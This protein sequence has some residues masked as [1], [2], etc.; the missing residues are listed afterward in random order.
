MTR[1]EIAKRFLEVK[2]SSDLAKLFN[3]TPRQLAYV[4]YH[5]NGGT[6]GAY[7]SFEIPKKR[8][9]TRAIHAPNPEIAY[10]QLK[11]LGYLS[12]IYE[13]RAS[14]HGF[15]MGRSI[16][17]NA[18]KHVNRRWVFNVDLEN[19]FPSIHF[20]RVRG[21]FLNPPFSFSADVSRILAHLVCYHGNLPQ[22]APTSPIVSN[23]ICAKLDRDLQAL[24]KTNR[25]M[26]SRYGDDIT[27]STDLRDFPTSIAMKQSGEWVVGGELK[28]IIE[29]NAFQVNKEKV[30]LRHFKQRQQVTGLVVNEK[31]NVGREY[32]RELRVILYDWQS[33][34]IVK[35]V[36]KFNS[37]RSISLTE[38]KFKKSIL[39][40]I[41]FVNTVRKLTTPIIPN[42][43]IVSKLRQS[44]YINVL[45]GS[46]LPMIKTEGQTDWKHLKFMLAQL[47]LQGRF[48]DLNIDF[49]EFH[50]KTLFGDKKNLGLINDTLTNP[51]IN[52]SVPVIFVF[53]SDSDYFAK[54]HLN[55]HQK[56]KIWRPGLF[57][58]TISDSGEC[59]ESL[60]SEE[61][62]AQSMAHRRLFLR[63]DF[64][65]DGVHKLDPSISLGEK[66]K[67]KTGQVIDSQVIKNSEDIALSK[68][69]FCKAI[70]KKRIQTNAAD[71]NRFSEVFER[72]NTAIAIHQASLKLADPNRE[73]SAESIPKSENTHSLA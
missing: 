21:L 57:S 13:P 59:I 70:V 53:D 10:L 20:G 17:T 2:Q 19:F 29:S 40:K 66:T 35:A 25:C 47:K 3:S 63:T 26:M 36:E 9:G 60:Y 62:R 49:F 71:L 65:K 4:L 64:Q 14:T 37:I 41:Q 73:E 7:R 38:S 39:G 33:K 24:A 32:I 23:M 44:F 11:L 51:K 52:F 6:D 68:M 27:F 12:A 42:D 56:I 43:D 45:L 46:H 16:F 15:Q 5:K 34:G 8:G 55:E 31:I 67:S 58:V 50:E 22:G 30:N 72:I 54:L 48:L 18:K 61:T 69:A 1:E 28:K